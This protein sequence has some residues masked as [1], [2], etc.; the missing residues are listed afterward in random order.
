MTLHDHPR[1]AEF[2]ARLDARLKPKLK[3]H[4]I[5]VAE[6][7]LTISEIEGIDPERCIEAGLLH[8]ACKHLKKDAYLAEAEKW[9][10]P[11]SDAARQHPVLLHGPLAAEEAWHDLGLYFD[12]LYH[13]L[14]WHTTGTP[15]LNRLGLALII[16]D[17]SEPNRDY[18]EAAKA[19]ALLHTRGFHE[20]LRFVADT[21]FAFVQ[22]KS[23]IDPET[24][25]F[26]AWVMDGGPAA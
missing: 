26:H 17:F 22:K 9:A 16:A 20:A 15:G 7:L 19:R 11:I 8:D 25:A 18:P 23:V 13:A 12:D 10:L 24:A 5:G 14:Y 6:T 2:L 3:R 1:A 21:K 4:C